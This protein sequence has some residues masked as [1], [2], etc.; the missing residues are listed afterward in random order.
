MKDGFPQKASGQKRL[1]SLI[2]PNAP[3][4]LTVLF[5]VRFFAIATKKGFYTKEIKR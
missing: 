2:L 3:W 5:V 1:Y 4:F